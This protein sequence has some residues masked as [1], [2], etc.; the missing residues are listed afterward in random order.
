MLLKQEIITIAQTL[1]KQPTTHNEPVVINNALKWLSKYLSGNGLKIKTIKHNSSISLL[2]TAKK[3]HSI[4]ILFHGHLDVVAAN[5]KQFTPKIK[6]DRLYGRGSLDMKGAL[7]VMV[8]FAKKNLAGSKHGLLITSD[9]EIGGYNGSGYLAESKTIKCNYFITGEPTNLHL[10]EEEKGV[11][12]LIAKIKG[13]SAHASTPWEGNNP[14]LGLNN[15]LQNIYLK[16]PNPDKEKWVTT[17][18]PTIIESKNSQNQIPGEIVVKLDCR[19]IPE[20][21]PTKIVETMAKYSD[22]VDIQLMEPIL[23]KINH[24]Y[25]TI[26]KKLTNK[27]GIRVN[28]A[29]DARFFYKAGI[30]SV[31][32]GP[33]GEN[34]HG[35]DEWVSISSLLKFYNVLDKL[36]QA[37]SV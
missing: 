31:V 9:E 22:G 28:Y 1:I 6:G 2:I 19:Y 20:D 18:V 13:Q 33:A 35:E 34:M 14:I 12:W 30:P 17:I 27:K 26:L 32:F 37:T 36:I 8:V 3:V 4:D 15:F 29:T 10:A 7:A 25:T 5:P 16:Y 21:N 23:G 24:P 11:I